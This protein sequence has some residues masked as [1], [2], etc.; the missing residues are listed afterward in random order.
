MSHYFTFKIVEPLDFLGRN[1]WLPSFLYKYCQYLWPFLLFPKKVEW[2][3]VFN[4]RGTLKLITWRLIGGYFP[5]KGKQSPSLGF[6]MLLVFRV[7][8]FHYKFDGTLLIAFC[9]QSNLISIF[10]FQRMPQ[11]V[12]NSLLPHFLKNY[13][14]KLISKRFSR[15]CEPVLFLKTS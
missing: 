7:N 4:G 14:A 10:F 13:T 2:K 8:L 15:I 1:M 9:V 6:R 5:Y 3:Q 12:S 11:I